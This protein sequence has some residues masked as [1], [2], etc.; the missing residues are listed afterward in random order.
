[1]CAHIWYLKDC[2]YT[3]A[4]HIQHMHMNDDYAHENASTEI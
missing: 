1:M 4:E 3:V 2:L